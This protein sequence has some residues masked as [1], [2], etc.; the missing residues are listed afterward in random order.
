MWT[1]NALEVLRARYL[2][3]NESPE[4]MLWRVANAISG[5]E[6]E[7]KEWA[8]KFFD[9]MA[10]LEFLPN[11]P[12][13]MN[14]GRPLG[15]LSACYVIPI[16]DSLPS[17][18]EAVKLAALIHKTGGGTGFSF[19]KI[20]PAG[21]M[22]N[23]TKGVASGPI[24]FMRAFNVATEIVKQGGVRRGA[25]LGALRVDHPDILAW[26]KCK[27]DIEE[28]NNFNISVAI[29]DQYMRCLHNS[30]LFYLRNPL[31][32]ERVGIDAQEIWEQ[33]LESIWLT[34][35]PGILFIDT[36]NRL[37][38]VKNAGLIECTNP[39][40]EQPLL[41]YE[42]CN[43]GSIDV[44]KLVSRNR[45]DFARFREIIK[46]AVR[47]LDDVIDVNKFPLVKIARKTRRFRKIGLGIMGWADLLY[48]LKIPYSSQEALQ[49]ADQIGAA[50]KREATRT[51]VALQKEKANMSGRRNATL[52]T[53]A[54][55]GTLSMLAD[56][57]SGIEPNFSLEYIKAAAGKNFHYS[58]KH[59]NGKK[60]DY[61]ETAFD[62]SPEQ[63]VRMQAAFQ[64]HID[65]AVSKTINLPP[66]A[67]KK[68]IGDAIQ[69]AYSLDCKGLT[70]Y[71]DGTRQA[72]LFRIEASA[73][74]VLQKCDG[75]MCEL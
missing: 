28:F 62:I 41:P 21:S 48:Q 52:L 55:T 26:I 5:Q 4:E 61:F 14:A 32:K 49:L 18:F 73:E 57:S 31:T 40:G 27:R 68:E 67:T 63:H 7:Q 16:E 69:L 24:S 66:T 34:G 70:L 38:P 58:N 20:R 22:V 74:E 71:R 42:S 60:E 17:I 6:I 15:Q 2:R 53:F 64:K 45:F 1:N 47:F 54:P 46:I 29:T 56:C 19:S 59:Y 33:L 8:Q 25:S 75:I 72:P 43:L 50:M 39:C 36:I 65:N 51:S 9:I 30:H 44:S 3:E 10:S 35:E 11:S 23:S 37:H 13:L 12:T